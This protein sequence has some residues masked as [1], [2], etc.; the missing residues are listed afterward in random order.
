MVKAIGTPAKGKIVIAPSVLSADLMRMGRHIDAVAK[1]GAD[2]IHLDIMDG[3]FVPNLSF[4]P[5]FSKAISAYTTLPV[6]THLMLD[7]PQDFVEPFAK[8]GS[9]VI[10]VHAEAIGKNPALLKKISK[11]GVKVGLSLKPDMPVRELKPFLKYIDLLL[12]MTVFPGFGGQGFLPG[13]TDRIAEARNL[14]AASKRKIWLEVDGGINKETAALAVRAGADAL[15][16][17][18]A[19]FGEK[20]P[21]AAV[22]RMR[23]STKN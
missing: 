23:S 12:V 11:L 6:D 17:G 8:A 4:G 15:V 7:N 19:V 22:R 20:S 21:A 13:S 3:H 10:T 5:A 18:N 1:G 9:A 16:A 14:I 2:W